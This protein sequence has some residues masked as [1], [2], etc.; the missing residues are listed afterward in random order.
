MKRVMVIGVSAGVGKTTFARKVGEKLGHPVT[1]LDSL[2]WKAGWIESELREFEQKQKEVVE[3][4]KW[5]IEGNY[6]STFHIR[7]QHADTIIYLELP[8]YVCL[9]RVVKRW[10]TNIGNTRPDMPEGCPEKLDWP[11]IKFI[12]T[13]YHPRKQKM[14]EQF[15]KFGKDKTIITLRSKQEINTYIRNF[16]H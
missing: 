8:L 14:A 5:I 4:D 1:H 15:K 10:L 6:N 11:F 3:Q 9:Y 12:Y 2:Y 13:T 16:H 7:A